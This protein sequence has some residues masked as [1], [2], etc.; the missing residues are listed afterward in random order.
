MQPESILADFRFA[1]HFS[2]PNILS[3]PS[4]ELSK[5]QNSVAAQYA[6]KR[7]VTKRI[8]GARGLVLSSL[9]ELKS[10]TIEECMI[11][12]IPA[13]MGIAQIPALADLMNPTMKK[14]FIEYK[15]LMKNHGKPALHESLLQFFGSNSMDREDVEMYLEDLSTTFDRAVEIIQSPSLGDFVN[16]AA[17]PVVIDASCE[18]VKDGFHREAMFWIAMMRAICQVTIQQDALEDEQTLYAEQYVKRLAELGLRSRDDLHRRAEDGKRLL[19]E[20]M[21]VADQIVETNEKIIQ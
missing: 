21:Q 14:C 5:T 15:I 1:C 19:D 4:G 2:V 8:E 7:W 20:V 16:N 17:R 18:L 6:K 10:G 9:E 12:F 3:D 13:V 11:H